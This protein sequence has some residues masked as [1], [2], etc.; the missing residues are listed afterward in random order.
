M[1]SIMRILLVVIF[2]GSCIVCDA[3]KPK[4]DIY[5]SENQRAIIY[6]ESGDSKFNSGDK[7]GALEDYNKALDADP[8]FLYALYNRSILKRDLGDVEGFSEVLNRA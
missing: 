7:V 2:L 6:R 8:N 5:D 3:A 4:K 1:K